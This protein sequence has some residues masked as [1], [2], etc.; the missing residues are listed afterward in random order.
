MHIHF[1]ILPQIS[2]YYCTELL[3]F[4]SSPIP[5]KRQLSAFL[6]NT[7]LSF[8]YFNFP[9]TSQNQNEMNFLQSKGSICAS[10]WSQSNKNLQ[11]IFRKYS[12]LSQC[13][14]RR[15]NG[16]H[17][18]T[19]VSFSK[20]TFPFTNMMPKGHRYLLG[21]HPVPFTKG[22]LKGL[23]S[24]KNFGNLKLFGVL[25]DDKQT[26]CKW[27]ECTVRVSAAHQQAHSKGLVFFSVYW[28]HLLCWS[29]IKWMEYCWF[30]LPCYGVKI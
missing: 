13:E 16:P 2:V 29:W 14:A 7:F 22:P 15:A 30:T 4:F 26:K 21:L 1:H 28:K 18:E 23:R 12:Q 9:L 27:E 10:V 17:K 6:Q 19:T 8:I 5:L 11:C 3:F 20:N 25:C 24:R